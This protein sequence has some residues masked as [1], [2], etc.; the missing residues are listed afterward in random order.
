MSGNITRAHQSI[1]LWNTMNDAA[2]FDEMLALLEKYPQAVS[3]IAL[4]TGDTHAPMPLDV[5][6]KRVDALVPLME[7]ARAKGFRC[8]INHLSLIGHHQEHAVGSLTD[9][10]FCVDINGDEH[11]GSLCLSHPCTL[12]YVRES[13]IMLAKAKPDFLWTDDD[14]RFFHNGLCCFCDH[15]IDTFNKRNELAVTRDDLRV[16]FADSNTHDANLRQLWRKFNASVLTDLFRV[17][18]KAADSVDPDLTIGSMSCEYIFEGWPYADIAD[19]LSHQQQTQT[20]WRPGGGVYT[21]ERLVGFVEKAHS[22]GRQAAALPDYVTDIQSEIENF[23][24]Q[25]ISKGT[26]ANMMESLLYVAAGCTGTALNIVPA[27]DEPLSTIEPTIKRAHELRPFFDLIA[28]TIG[29]VRPVGIGTG[30]NPATNFASPLNTNGWPQSLRHTEEFGVIGLP[31]AYENTSATVYALTAESV[32]CM[33]DAQI[34]QVLA[35]GVYCDADAVAA[36]TAR[37]FGQYIGFAV[38]EQFPQ[39]TME[40][41]TD[42][43]LNGD[44]A[45]HRRNCRQSFSPV[46][47]VAFTP[48]ENAQVLASLVD[49]NRQEKAACTMGVFENTLG[50]RVCVC[51]YFPWTMLQELGKST[52]IKNVFDWLANGRLPAFVKSYH[53]ANIWTRSLPDG[54]T[55]VALLNASLDRAENLELSVQSIGKTAHFYK[56]SDYPQQPNGIRLS[57]RTDKDGSSVYRL[58]ALNAWEV[59]LL[60]S[61]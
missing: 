40:Q 9:A 34:M 5:L 56:M 58:P 27:Y 4:F 29:R 30:W 26:H 8:G 46:P 14:L 49:Y 33:D 25:F 57:A 10:A 51:G 42:H 37:G 59:A 45:G 28:S 61:D 55:A 22:L 54:R 2:R 52:Q 41:Y 15:C 6:Q 20:K 18:R 35:D 17:V 3:E 50:G 24:Y 12:D 47:A 38:A 13:I 7:K 53:R 39:D 23:P 32:S 43:P 16:A 60:I 44:F 36:L 19:V 48:F 1:R 21:D 31:L 11:L